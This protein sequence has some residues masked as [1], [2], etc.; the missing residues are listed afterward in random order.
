MRQLVVELVCESRFFEH[1]LLLGKTRV[2]MAF[3]KNKKIITLDNTSYTLF[4]AVNLSK[5]NCKTK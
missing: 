2:H 3:L 1:A 4:Y 5:N